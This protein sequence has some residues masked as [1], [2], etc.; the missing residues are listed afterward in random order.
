[1]RRPDDR[2][3]RLEGDLLAVELEAWACRSQCLRSCAQRSHSPPIMFSE[4]KVGT[5]SAIMPP[6]DQLLEALQVDEARRADAHAVRRAA[7]V[8]HEVE[9]ELAVA[10]LGVRVDL[11]GGHLRRPPSRA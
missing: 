8:G 2:V 3:A 6:R 10:A 4:P 9:A 11:A 7:A 1:M 5:M